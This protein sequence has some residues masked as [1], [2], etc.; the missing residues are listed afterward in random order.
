M[1][2]IEFGIKDIVD[3]VL[4]ATM[5]YYVY[6]V[7]KKSGAASIFIGVL[8]F[9]AIWYLATRVL[10]MEMLGGIFDRI[11]NVGAFAIVVLFQDEIRRFFSRIGS[12]KHWSIF[13]VFKKIFGTTDK[14]KKN[15]EL[16]QILISCRN[17]ARNHVGALIV[18]TRTSDLEFY[19]QSGETIDANVNSR[20]IEN[21][22]FKN[23]PLH[24][25]ALMVS[26]GRLKAAGCILPVSRNT[27]ISKS[28]GLRHRAAIGI[29]EQTDAVAVVVSEET[30]YMSY[31]VGGEITTRVSSEQLETFLSSITD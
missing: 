6:R 23:S 13:T 1:F 28:L 20:L 11:I 29:T 24:D 15:Y 5:L 3:I 26:N 19:A 16:Q 31:A 2:G 4:A 27:N 18:I 7:L 10:R 30:G 25:G 21:I 8:I 22:F 12:Q 14:E 17:L 9:I